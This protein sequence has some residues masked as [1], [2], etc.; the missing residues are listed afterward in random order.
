ML[1][2]PPLPPP[3]PLTKSNIFISVAALFPHLWFPVKI[4]P[5]LHT[6]T[7]KCLIL[8]GIWGGEPFSA[9][10]IDFPQIVY[11]TCATR[12]SILH[13]RRSIGVLFQT[14]SG[15]GGEPCMVAF[16][17]ICLCLLPCCP[18]MLVCCQHPARR[19]GLAPW[20][21]Q[22]AH[23]LQ[24]AAD[25]DLQLRVWT[26]GSLLG[27]LPFP[28]RQTLCPTLS[29]S[30]VQ[31]SRALARACHSARV[32]G[33]KPVVMNAPWCVRRACFKTE[34]ASCCFCLCML[35][36]VCAAL[37]SASRATA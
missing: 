28:L 26:G 25:G 31:P 19:R 11:C 33:C 22:H 5:I 24:G 1:R 15:S 32:C 3:V 36:T 17:E 27:L 9:S 14:A 7:L 10:H 6:S 16:L 37:C 21:D 34:R 29:S 23:R 20:P 12:N 2:S 8:Y 18:A 4:R 35:Y 13:A 30:P